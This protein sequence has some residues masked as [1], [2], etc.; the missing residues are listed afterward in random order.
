MDAH[1][2]LKSRIL[3]TETG[4]FAF[5]CQLNFSNHRL[6]GCTRGPL[7]RH[8]ARPAAGP[9]HGGTVRAVKI[10][11]VLPM[12]V[13]VMAVLVGGGA[14][15]LRTGADERVGE[16]NEALVG[17]FIDLADA[18]VKPGDPTGSVDCLNELVL[19]QAEPTG[20]ATVWAGILRAVDRHPDAFAAGCHWAA[21]KIGEYAGRT[22]GDVDRALSVGSADCQFGYFHGVIEGHAAVTPT[23]WEELPGLC[24]KVTT[25]Q[26]TTAYAEC[27]HSLGHA[28][29]TRTDDD[30]RAGLD[31]CKLINTADDRMACDTGIFMSWSNTLDRLLGDGETLEAKFTIAPAD[32]RW[33]LCPGLNDTIEAGACVLFFAETAPMTVPGIMEF[34]SWCAKTFSGRPEVSKRCHMGVGRVIGGEA[35]FRIVDGWAGVV[36]I[37]G[38]EAYGEDAIGWCSETSAATASGFNQNPVM[39][40]VACTAW[41]LHRLGTRECERIRDTHRTVNGQVNP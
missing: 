12:L 32:R 10:R 6:S 8:L 38:D 7:S 24:L 4:T 31:G 39:V 30:V 21:H 22:T 40:D 28:I 18:C 36:R 25:D 19:T 41:K 11:H 37:C 20:V 15:F 33:E 17:R 14:V 2:A 29:V 27:S 16:V 5:A 34:R 35:G 13:A 1:R 3:E 9:C 23:L 26:D